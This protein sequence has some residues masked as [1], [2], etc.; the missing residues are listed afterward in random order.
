MLVPK[1]VLDTTHKRVTFLKKIR[2]QNLYTIARDPNLSVSVTLISMHR[3][4]KKEIILNVNSYFQMAKIW[5]YF[6]N[7]L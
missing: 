3:N 6:P 1:M 4:R 5:I 7:P 2:I